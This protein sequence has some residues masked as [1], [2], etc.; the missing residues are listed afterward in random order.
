MPTTQRQEDWIKSA[1]GRGMD[2]DGVNQ[3]QCV[4]VINDYGN[5]LFGSWE[6]TVGRGNAKDKYV[7]MPASYWE[8]IPNNPRD[9]NQLPERGDVIVWPGFTVV[10]NGTTVNN[11]AGHIAVVLSATPT[12]VTTIAQ[13][14]F[15]KTRPAFQVTYPL[16]LNG[17]L[18]IGWLRPRLDK[19][20][21]AE[22]TIIVKP[23]DQL[24][25]HLA[26]PILMWD[27]EHNK[28]LWNSGDDMQITQKTNIINGD[29]YYVPIDRA[30]NG[31]LFGFKEKDVFAPG[32]A[33][34]PAPLPSADPAI[35]AKAAKFDQIIAITKGV[36]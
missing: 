10:L 14:G 12:S 23:I 32:N 6:Q 28:S 15:Y 16:L 25:V 36:N 17:V 4:D 21:G 11:P 34:T 31:E 26:H 18:P 1:I 7:N 24:N 35:V 30:Q 33:I 20:I 27:F 9:P 13:D 22:M 8:K 2:L 19:Q 5:Y 29:T 3:F